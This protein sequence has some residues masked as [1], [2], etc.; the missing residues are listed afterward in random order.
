MPQILP[1]PFG[2]WW[3]CPGDSAQQ[4][5]DCAA[6][7]RDACLAIRLACFDDAEHVLWS[8]GDSGLRD[9]AWLNVMGVVYESRGAWR[10]AKRFYGK[11][12]RADPGFAPAEQ[13]MRRW[14]ELFTFGRTKWPVALGDDRTAE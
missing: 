8:A 4:N 9:A 5:R 1:K 3:G 6:A 2:R 10:R 11:S 14:Y 7:V 12:M 13:N